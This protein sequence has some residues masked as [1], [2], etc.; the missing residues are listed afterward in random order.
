MQLK[1]GETG[2]RAPSLGTSAAREQD[3]NPRFGTCSRRFLCGSQNTAALT[4]SCE[5]PTLA[6][7]PRPKQSSIRIPRVDHP[8]LWGAVHVVLCLLLS[9]P[10]LSAVRRILAKLQKGCEDSCH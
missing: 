2:G 8:Q 1:A 4:S 7:M 10:S 9:Y 3:R 5:T 6:A